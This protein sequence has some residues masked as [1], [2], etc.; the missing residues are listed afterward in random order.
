MPDTDYTLNLWRFQRIQDAKLKGN[1]GFELPPLWLDA[2]CAG[3]AFRP[4]V[5]YAQDLEMQRDK[6]ADNYQIA[7]TQ[8][9][10]DAPLYITPQR[11]AYF[12]E[13]RIEAR[14]AC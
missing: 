11:D 8:D 9:V 10:E 1:G 3:M 4:A 6:L 12:D 13:A 2:A 14:M 5:H 7:A